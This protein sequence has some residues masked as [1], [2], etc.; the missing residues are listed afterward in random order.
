ML[1]VLGSRALNC[2]DEWVESL[3]ISGSS[4]RRVAD[5]GSSWLFVSLAGFRLV[6]SPERYR[7]P[8]QLKDHSPYSTALAENLQE[9]QEA[10]DGMHDL[11]WSVGFQ[12]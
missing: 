12:I 1:L 2:I 3:A 5:G 4:Q 7:G 6:M 11:T 9:V 8:L 10:D